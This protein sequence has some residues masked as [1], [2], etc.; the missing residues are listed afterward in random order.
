MFEGSRLFQQRDKVP[1]FV[2]IVVEV[3]KGSFVKRLPDGAV[4]YVGPM[5]SPFNYGSVP[6][7]PAP[8]GNAHISPIMLFLFRTHLQHDLSLQREYK[9]AG[10]EDLWVEKLYHASDLHKT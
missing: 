3:P 8:D 6:A 7:I 10:L 9:Q 2:D 4:D 5:P 1:G